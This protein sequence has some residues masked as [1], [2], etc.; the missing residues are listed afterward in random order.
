MVRRRK[1]RLN[2]IKDCGKDTKVNSQECRKTKVREGR[3]KH[4]YYD[5]VRNFLSVYFSLIIVIL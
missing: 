4:F 5:L 3:L 1:F 2:K